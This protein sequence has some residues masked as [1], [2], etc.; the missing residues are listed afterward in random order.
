MKKLWLAV[1]L[2]AAFSSAPAADPAVAGKNVTMILKNFNNPFFITVRD[3]GEA[4]ARELGINLTVL[5]PLKA[6]NNEE[7]THMVEQ[8][9]ASGADLVIMCPS[10]TMGIVPAMEKLLEAGIPVVNLNTRIGGDKKL[11]ETFVAAEEYQA[12]FEAV[13]HLADLIGEKGEFIILEGV[14]GAQVAID[15][16]KGARAALELYPGIKLVASQTAEFNRARGMDVMQNL[17]QAHPNVKCV[18]ACNDEM[19]LGAVEAIAAAN[20]TGQIAVGGTDGNND[21]RQAIRDGKMAV[22]CFTNPFNQ[23]YQSVMAASR[24]LKGEKLPE[25]FGV[26]VQLLGKGDV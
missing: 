22:T 14:P 11:A 8:A 18:Y 17:I 25:V 1:L 15:R 20:K 23:G 3:G 5:A 26:S 16:L 13:K 12:G 4:A 24:V 21:A 9:I 7:Q 19:A 6:N 10:D 2:S